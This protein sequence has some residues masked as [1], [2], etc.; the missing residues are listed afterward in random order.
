MK[1]I[2]LS[3]LL[4]AIFSPMA[5]ATDLKITDFGPDSQADFRWEIVNDGVMGGLSQGTL[6]MTENGTMVFRGTL[7]L[8]NNGGFS[9]VR[10]GEIP[11]DL[12]QAS[13][14]ILRV[15]GDGR[16]YQMRLLTDARVGNRRVS[17]MAPF[18]TRDG[19]WIEVKIPF[20]AFRGTWR[21]EPVKEAVLD[22]AKVA[23]L[24]FQLSDGRVGPFQLEVD[25][26]KSFADAQ[27]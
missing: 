5:A 3:L 21:G 11:L 8:E 9:S 25:W 7:S 27:D 18:P 17:F 16:T 12:S 24:G 2:P 14:V 10:S 4:L 23:G 19:A 13:G 6:Q 20:S 26:V 1:E 15:R 22:P